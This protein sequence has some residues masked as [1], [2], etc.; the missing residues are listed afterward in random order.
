VVLSRRFAPGEIGWGYAR[1]LTQTLTGSGR[2][3]PAVL[4]RWLAGLHRLDQ[5]GP[6]CSA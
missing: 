6:S 1:N 3:D 2:A 5:R 4:D